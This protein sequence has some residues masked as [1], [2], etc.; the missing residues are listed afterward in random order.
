MLWGGVFL[1]ACNM[2]SADIRSIDN[3]KPEK[4]YFTSF[5]ECGYS[6][7]EK[8]LEEKINSKLR[9]MLIAGRELKI[10]CNILNYD[11]GSRFARYMVGFGAGSASSVIEIKLLDSNDIEIKTFEVATKLTA[12]AFGGDDK[13]M[14]DTAADKI[15]DYVKKNYIR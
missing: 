15:I 5:A 4:V 7:Q 3:K 13:N 12:G 11:E 10:Q 8:Y 1:T 2:A 9:E 6:A 14:L